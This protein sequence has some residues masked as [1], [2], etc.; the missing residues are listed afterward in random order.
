MQ[1]SI[2]W[3]FNLGESGQGSFISVRERKEFTKIKYKCQN[4]Y[5]PIIG[6]GT[7]L[8]STIMSGF[9]M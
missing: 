5:L 6:L 4:I 3:H 1:R 7:G 2:G 9:G 8:G